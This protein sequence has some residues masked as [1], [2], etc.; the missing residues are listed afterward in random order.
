MFKYRSI[1]GVY[2]GLLFILMGLALIDKPSSGTAAYLTGIFTLPLIAGGFLISG[3]AVA[4]TGVL[5]YKHSFMWYSAFY[6][7]VIAI[8]VLA[9]ESQI[10]IFT[11][12]VYALLAGMF[13]IEVGADM[14]RGNKNGKHS[15]NRR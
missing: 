7:Y 5:Q 11:L 1:R 4:V 8:F 3:V 10:P 13:T 2:V 14:L 6:A 12:L 9:N 15:R